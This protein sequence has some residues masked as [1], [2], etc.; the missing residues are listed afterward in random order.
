MLLTDGNIVW[1]RQPVSVQWP[2]ESTRNNE[3][4]V[5]PPAGEGNYFTLKT[6]EIDEIDQV[7]QVDH[8]YANL[9]L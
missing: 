3:V 8:L 2:M 1:L 7:D 5:G 9:P 4:W 6:D